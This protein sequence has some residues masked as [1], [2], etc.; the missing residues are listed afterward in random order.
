MLSDRMRWQDVYCDHSDDDPFPKMLE[1]EPDNLLG[2]Y[3]A[4]EVALV[5]KVQSTKTLII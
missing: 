2:P 4:T 5:D 3:V 1:E